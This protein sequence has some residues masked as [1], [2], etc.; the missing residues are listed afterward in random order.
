MMF[1]CPHCD[2]KTISLWKKLFLDPRYKYECKECGGYINIPYY[3]LIVFGVIS[4][5]IVY[6][7]SVV[8]NKGWIYTLFILALVAIIYEVI[9]LL[10]VPIIKK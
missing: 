9:V 1:K 6:I 8:L 2:K 10:F 3:T 5:I 4:L 7:I